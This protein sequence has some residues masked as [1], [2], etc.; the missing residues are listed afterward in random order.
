MVSHVFQDLRGTR[1]PTHL[2]SNPDIEMSTIL[3][4]GATA[5]IR[6][7]ETPPT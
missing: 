1:P 4:V 7:K 6:P 2:F 3:N 5:K